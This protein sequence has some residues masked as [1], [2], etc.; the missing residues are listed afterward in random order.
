MKVVN[1]C[2]SDS[3]SES[4]NMILDI[5]YSLFTKPIYGFCYTSLPFLVVKLNTKI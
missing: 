2:I 5:K 3:E 1:Q 4:E